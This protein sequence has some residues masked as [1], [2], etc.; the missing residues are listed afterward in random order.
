MSCE[1]A[2]LPY[3]AHAN[4]RTWSIDFG[5]YNINRGNYKFKYNF[6]TNFLKVFKGGK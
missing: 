5:V 1:V 2:A 6:T 4:Y 3:Q